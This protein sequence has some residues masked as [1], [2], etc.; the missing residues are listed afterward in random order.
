MAVCGLVCVLYAVLFGDLRTKKKTEIPTKN[1]YILVAVL[2]SA[3]AA[4]CALFLCVDSLVWG[5]LEDSLAGWLPT[6][7]GYCIPPMLFL[8][9][10]K[11][12]KPILAILCFCVVILLSILAL[13]ILLEESPFDFSIEAVV[14]F[15]LLLLST[16]ASLVLSVGAMIKAKWDFSAYYNSIGYREKCYKRVEKMKRYLDSGVI[17]QEEFEKAKREIVKHIPQ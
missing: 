2:V 14:T 4:F 11:K 13:G 15:L 17:S 10:R 12:M 9:N 6:F 8:L 7:F 16:F 3:F 5:E 1:T